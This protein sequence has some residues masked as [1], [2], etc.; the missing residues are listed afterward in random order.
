[1]TAIHFSVFSWGELRR[2]LHRIFLRY[3]SFRK[4]RTVTTRVEG[5]DLIVLPSVFHPKYFGSSAIFAR[6]INTLSLQGKSFLDLGCGSG[7]IALCAARSGAKVTAVD[8]NPS[9][10]E[11]TRRN[12]ERARLQIKT[13][14]SDVFA[15][16]RESF[17]VIAW[18]PPYL[19]GSPKDLAE[20]AFFGGPEYEV[21]QRFVLEARK[22]LKNGG[23]IYTIVSTDA[24][25]DFICR[26]FN[27]HGL[28]AST[29]ASQTWLFQ[30]QLL[31]LCSEL[32]N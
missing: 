2:L 8:I 20:S 5:F 6:F 24:D 29:A 21:I 13:E 1:M 25:V 22:H 10:V 17:D 11:T 16:V 3:W 26:L 19:P 32:V 12:A 27:T 18:N 14:V 30:E 15:N 9:A 7:I 4:N 23:R 31:I 28:S